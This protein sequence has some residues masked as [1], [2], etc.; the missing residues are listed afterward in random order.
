VPTQ[1]LVAVLI[2]PPGRLD[3][4]L[5]ETATRMLP[6]ARPYRWL[7]PGEAAEITFP[8]SCKEPLILTESLRAAVGSRPIDVAIVPAAHRRKRL[9][10]ADMDSTL[11]GQE[12][13]D[14]LAK[15]AGA[16]PEVAAITERSMRGELDFEQSLAER[17]R[18]LAGLPESA[19]A[20]ILTS[21]ISLNPGARQLATT[22]R[23]H[24]ALTVIVS[25]GFAAFTGEVRTRAGFDRDL[26]NRL[27]IVNGRLTGRL[28]PPILGRHAKREALQALT[29]ELGLSPRETLAVGDGANDIEMIRAAGLGVAYR[30]K[31]ALRSVA[32]ACIDHTDLT[33]LLYL[34][35]YRVQDLEH[36]RPAGQ[37]D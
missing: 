29:A 23:R 28:A 32:N 16:G 26:S 10:V 20:E 15:L 27:E 13:I 37:Q 21:R 19:F 22:M 1:E 7:S 34:Q 6:G 2:A 35:G 30:A 9:L 18:L 31:P 12:C 33:A 14:E 8:A 5:V 24:G 17:V 4:A 3:L 11:I 25:G 36:D